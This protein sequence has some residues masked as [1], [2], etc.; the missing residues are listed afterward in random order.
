[1]DGTTKRAINPVL[2]LFLLA[3]ICVFIGL[4]FALKGLGD[5]GLVIS[6]SEF[7]QPA[8]VLELT[9]RYRFMAAAMFFGAAMLAIFVIFFLELFT[10]YTRT[11]IV[12][13]I[14]AIAIGAAVGI[15]SALFAPSWTHGIETYHLLGRQFFESALGQGGATI[16][17]GGGCAAEGGFHVYESVRGWVNSMTALSTAAALTGMVLSLSRSPSNELPD[18][19]ADLVRTQDVVQRY[20]YCAGLLLSAGMIFLISWMNWPAGLIPDATVKEAYSG[21]VSAITLY[22]GVAYSIMILSV[23]LPVMLIFRARSED[24]RA[25]LM[26][27]PGALRDA[28]AMVEPPRIAYLDAVKA[29]VAILSPILAS[30]IGSFGQGVLFG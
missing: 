14:S 26:S 6:H 4:E 17:A 29:V 28:E 27:D 11:T 1:M 8:A 23:Y 2:L 25:R 30:A 22:V 10:T 24:Y 16:C 13:A 15:V 12:T 19:G 20:L 3:P 18:A 9:G 7:A 21:M 5:G